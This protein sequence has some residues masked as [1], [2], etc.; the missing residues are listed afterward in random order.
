[1]MGGIRMHREYAYP[2]YA[3]NSEM[4]SLINQA[5]S[6]VLLAPGYTSL[7]CESQA[8][9]LTAAVL[10]AIK[11]SQAGETTESLLAKAA[12]DARIIADYNLGLDLQSLAS[13]YGISDRQIRRIVEKRRQ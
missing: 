12:R 10:E 7:N 4:F 6:G 13:R 8:W 9:Q 11:E 2:A 3:A 1:M 5:I